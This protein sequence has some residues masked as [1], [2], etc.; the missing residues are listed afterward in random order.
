MRSS[1]HF[2]RDAVE[3]LTLCLRQEAMLDCE[4][5]RTH[6]IGHADLGIDVLDV[7]ARGL[8]RNEESFGDLLRGETA[9]E[10]LK[11]LDLAPRQS[12]RPF[13]AASHTVSSRCE[14][15]LDCVAIQS[16]GSYIAAE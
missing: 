13:S 7:V 11:N 2:E 9:G 6:T 5:A 4:Q 1:P 15:G 10:Q 3:T 12:G 16:T 14:D 8:G